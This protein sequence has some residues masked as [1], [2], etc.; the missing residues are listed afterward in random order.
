MTYSLVQEVYSA[1]ED[2][3][4]VHRVGEWNGSRTRVGIPHSFSDHQISRP[5]E[6]INV[7]INS[8]CSAKLRHLFSH[9][10]RARGN[11]VNPSPDLEFGT[12]L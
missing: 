9:S 3:H 8:A 1:R 5:L 11:R 10:P 2:L 12:D 6:M 7:T 4:H